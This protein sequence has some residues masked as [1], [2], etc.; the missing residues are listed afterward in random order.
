[1]TRRSRPSERYEGRLED[2]IDQAAVLFAERGYAAVGVTELGEAAGL[3]RGALYYYIGS[4]EYLLVAIQNRVLEPLLAQA[5]AILEI[6][7]R[8]VARLRLLSEALLSIILTRVDH[9]RVYEHDYVHL[10][11][12]NR[13]RVLNQRREFEGIVQGL[14]EQAMADGSLR[15]LD[16]HLAA[17][18]FLNLHNHTYQWARTASRR[19]NAPEL[20][21]EYCQTLF[22]GMARDGGE[23]T[24]SEAEV[25]AA[26]LL[27]AAGQPGGTPAPTPSAR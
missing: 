4:K 9:I 20:S 5:T 27:V 18:Q 6:E 22:H 15:D 12:Q 3:G 23:L 24:I 25:E 8:P 14:L 7:A 19:W 17:L 10:T 21:R 2:I 26:R 1:M 16:P 13:K 11:G